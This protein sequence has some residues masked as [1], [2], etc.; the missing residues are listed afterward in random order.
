MESRKLRSVAWFARSDK[1][2]FIHRSWMRGYPSDVFDGRPIIGICNTWSELTPCNAHFRDL[3]ERVQRLGI[4]RGSARVP[5]H[6][7]RR[8]EYPTDGDAAA[9]SG[10][11]GWGG[12]D[13]RPSLDGTV[14][15]CRCDKAVPA[16]IIGAASCDL[17][18]IT[19]SGA[20]L[21]NG[22]FRGEDIGSGT[23]VL[24]FS[25]RGPAVVFENIEDYHR[26]IEDPNLESAHLINGERSHDFSSVVDSSRPRERPQQTTGKIVTNLWRKSAPKTRSFERFTHNHGSSREWI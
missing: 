22:E 4:R 7:L 24:R 3:A 21:L 1:N 10:E 19:V 18:T 20:P 2:G 9:Q 15:L 25:H 11:H 17:P 8:D 16:L 23:D 26:R 12:I 6:F 5:G 13:P 14:L